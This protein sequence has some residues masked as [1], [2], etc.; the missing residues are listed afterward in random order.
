MFKSIWPHV[1]PSV[2][3]GG[4]CCYGNTTG[5]VAMATPMVDIL[6]YSGR[7]TT[8]SRP[9][10]II[11]LN[12]WHCHMEMLPPDITQNT[13]RKSPTSSTYLNQSHSHN[14]LLQ[15]TTDHLPRPEN[16]SRQQWL[17]CNK[18][19]HSRLEKPVTAPL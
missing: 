17:S 9:T 1:P 11:I 18:L 19:H 13:V 16:W 5:N 4:V 12:T 14:Q 3:C 10:I 2:G 6:T 15:L 8:Q 7:V